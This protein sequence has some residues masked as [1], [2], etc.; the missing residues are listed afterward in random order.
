MRKYKPFSFPLL[1]GWGG[2]TIRISFYFQIASNRKLTWSLF[3]LRQPI[4]QI[5]S[6]VIISKM[7]IRL[8]FKKAQLYIIYP[9]HL[10]KFINR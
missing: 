10:F 9:K 7:T 4:F 3:Q 5:T 2:S 1:G 8:D 6:N